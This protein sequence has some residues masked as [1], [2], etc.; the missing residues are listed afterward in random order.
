MTFT[1]KDRSARRAQRPAHRT[2]RKTEQALTPISGDHTTDA[3]RSVLAHTT[4][5]WNSLRHAC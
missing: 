1:R 4:A 3:M 5:G 2:A